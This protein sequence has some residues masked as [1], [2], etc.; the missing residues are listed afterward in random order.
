MG[1]NIHYAISSGLA[2]VT[3]Q[4]IIFICIE[5]PGSNGTKGVS[6]SPNPEEEGEEEDRKKYWVDASFKHRVTFFPIDIKDM[7]HI[8]CRMKVKTCIYFS[9]PASLPLCRCHHPQPTSYLIYSQLHSCS[10]VLSLSLPLHP[11]P[12]SPCVCLPR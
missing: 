9:K 2:V 11:P 7:L 1:I 6:P 3:S 4:R 5:N 8:S 12:P 10:T